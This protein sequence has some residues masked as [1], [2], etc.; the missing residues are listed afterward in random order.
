AI[1]AHRLL[2]ALEG[3]LDGLVDRS[4]ERT[5]V[6][7]QRNLRRM[8]DARAA[9]HPRVLHPRDPARGRL[10]LATLHGNERLAQLPDVRP[11][12]AAA[13][14]VLP[15]ALAHQHADAGKDRRRA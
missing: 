15:A 5:V 6:R 12:L 1:E 9:L 11:D 10:D 8:I 13:D 3:E 2:E 4:D 14:R 7:R